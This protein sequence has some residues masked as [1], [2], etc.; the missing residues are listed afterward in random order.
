MR[1]ATQTVEPSFRIHSL[2]AYFILGGD[3]AEPVRYEVDRVRNGR[4]FATR[5]V[6]A[7]QSGGAILTLGCSFQDFGNAFF[8]A[9]VDDT[10]RL[11]IYKAVPLRS[12]PALRSEWVALLAAYL[13]GTAFV[14][15]RQRRSTNA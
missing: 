2:H 4:S 13:A 15:I 9:S 12:V 5:R 1:A 8:R 10:S 6:L 3:L 11:G 7:R 14:L